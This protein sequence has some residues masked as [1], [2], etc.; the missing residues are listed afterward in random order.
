MDL[1]SMLESSIRMLESSMCGLDVVWVGC[2][3]SKARNWGKRGT[4]LLIRLAFEQA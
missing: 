3:V 1:Y 2:C 4:I